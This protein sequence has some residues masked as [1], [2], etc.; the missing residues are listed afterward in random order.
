MLDADY[1]HANR[2][3]TIAISLSNLFARIC[4]RRLAVNGMLQS[5]FMQIGINKQ[6]TQTSSKAAQIMPQN[7]AYVSPH[8]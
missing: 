5:L 6:A 3:E 1:P 7:E 8:T 2:T 4:Y